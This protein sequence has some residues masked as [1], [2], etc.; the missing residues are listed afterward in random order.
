VVGS[1]GVLGARMAGRYRIIDRFKN[2]IWG[3]DLSSGSGTTGLAVDALTDQLRP[4]R[5]NEGEG[6]AHPP[7]AFHC[8]QLTTDILKTGRSAP[9][10]GWSTSSLALKSLLKSC[11]HV[12]LPP[13]DIRGGRCILGIINPGGRAE[14]PRRDFGPDAGQ[15]S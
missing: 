13:G 15:K 6:M 14:E 10:D 5:R 7:R 3:S 4:Y 9:P 2:R 1:R 8:S 11:R 12:H